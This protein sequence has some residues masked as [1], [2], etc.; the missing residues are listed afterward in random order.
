[1][2]TTDFQVR[3]SQRPGRFQDAKLN[4]F[5]YSEPDVCYITFCEMTS[6]V[7]QAAGGSAAV[8]IQASL[9]LRRITV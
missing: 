5:P 8:I 2:D 1:M 7:A 3:R 6:D 9:M 4:Q